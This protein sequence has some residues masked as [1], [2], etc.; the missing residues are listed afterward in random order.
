MLPEYKRINSHLAIIAPEK[1]AQILISLLKQLNPT[2][3]QQ[4]E[5]LNSL[6]KK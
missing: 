3:S 5:I 1:K 4:D 6:K 2:S